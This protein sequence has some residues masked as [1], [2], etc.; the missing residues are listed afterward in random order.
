MLSVGFTGTQGMM[1]NYKL[2]C[3][4][5][6]GFDRFSAV[7]LFIQRIVWEVAMDSDID[8]VYYAWVS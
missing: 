7:L 4:K 8:Y 5:K 2:L 1:L 6:Q 3:N